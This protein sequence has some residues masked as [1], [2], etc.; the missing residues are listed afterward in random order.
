MRYQSEVDDGWQA[1]FTS[2]ARVH[3]QDLCIIRAGTPPQHALDDGA[4]AVTVGMVT[5]KR[6]WR[7]IALLACCRS[8]I[9]HRRQTRHARSHTPTPTHNAKYRREHEDKEKPPVEVNLCPP[10]PGLPQQ[11]K[12]SNNAPPLQR[13]QASSLPFHRQRQ[14][15]QYQQ[16]H[17][18][19]TE[20]QQERDPS[21]SW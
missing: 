10:R 14:H 5:S 21:C 19:E 7:V 18:Q 6:G 11:S 15:Q 13:W 8:T 1:A 17:Q 3:T 20:H 4:D 12:Q 2:K 16:Q 9:K